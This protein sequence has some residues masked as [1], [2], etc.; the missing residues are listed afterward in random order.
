MLLS[1]KA[2]VRKKNLVISYLL[3]EKC[4]VFERQMKEN[5]TV[6]KCQ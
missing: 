6:C 3:C 4:Q 5:N 1:F 2:K